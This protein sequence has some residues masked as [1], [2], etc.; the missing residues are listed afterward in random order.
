VIRDLIRFDETTGRCMTGLSSIQIKR[1]DPQT[2]D[3]AC[4]LVF[5]D[6]SVSERS[7]RIS[8]LLDN[9]GS[10]PNGLFVALRSEGKQTLPVGATLLEPISDTVANL[11]FP[12][13]ALGESNEIAESL[14]K[15][16]VDWWS[17]IGGTMVQA[18]LPLGAL[19]DEAVLIANG[20]RYI[21][22][23]EYLV[24]QGECFPN[25]P[26]ETFLEFEPFVPGEIDRLCR[27]IE[28]TYRD[29]LDFDQLGDFLSVSDLVESYQEKGQFDPDR[30]LIGSFEGEDRAVVLVND[31]PNVAACELVYM[32]LVP[33]ARGNSLGRELTCM[34]AWQAAMAGRDRLIV[35]VDRANRPAISVYRSIGFDFSAK[36]AVYARFFQS[37]EGGS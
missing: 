6:L 24:L 13:L 7:S 29:S 21:S 10:L 33:E 8:S 22:E 2:V 37:G 34:A 3:A 25:S 23:L 32:G 36:R 18:L 9:Q 27:V 5:S 26:P 15:N 17:S 30:W 31:C 28:R 4:E 19:D 11:R 35:G 16:T 1:A 14:L 12:R 20:F